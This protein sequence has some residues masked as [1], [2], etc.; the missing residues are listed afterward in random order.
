MRRLTA[1]PGRA[2][3]L[4]SAARRH[5]ARRH[6]PTRYLTVLLG[7]YVHAMAARSAG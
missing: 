4:G 7:H 2:H 3:E 5:I 1:D 6:D